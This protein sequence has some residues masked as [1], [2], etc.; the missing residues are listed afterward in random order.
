[1]YVCVC[2]YARVYVRAHARERDCA[3]MYAHCELATFFTLRAEDFIV[4]QP[5]RQGGDCFHDRLRHWLQTTERSGR[6]RETI[7]ETQLRDKVT[8]RQSVTES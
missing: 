5:V 8:D 1:M 7:D 6:K 4:V 3:R 2:V